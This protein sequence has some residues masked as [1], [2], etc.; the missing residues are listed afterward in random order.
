MEQS[1]NC[2]YLALTGEPLLYINFM[3]LQT[4]IYSVELWSFK[5]AIRNMQKRP[6]TK[7]IESV[8]CLIQK[9]ST[10]FR[11]FGSQLA[12]IWKFLF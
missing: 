7:L 5:T 11:F 12:K 8:S 1:F 2:G 6:G 4:F 10:S 9:K 3:L